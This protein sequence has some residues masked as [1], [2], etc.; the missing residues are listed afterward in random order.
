MKIGDVV[1]TPEGKGTITDSANVPDDESGTTVY[2][3]VESESGEQLVES[4]YRDDEVSP[5]SSNPT[6]L[7]SYVSIEDCTDPIYHTQG[8]GLVKWTSTGFVF[9]TKPKCPGFDV[10]D[11][12]PEEWDIQPANT[13]ARQYVDH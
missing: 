9:V 8:G 4:W 12:M 6:G 7:G 3:L 5:V 10:G 13:A 1:L 2:Y 11:T